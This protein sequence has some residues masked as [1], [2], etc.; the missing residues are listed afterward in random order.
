MSTLKISDPNLV[1]FSVIQLLDS[2]NQPF[3]VLDS[4]KT[5]KGDVY[6]RFWDGSAKVIHKD[7]KVRLVHTPGGVALIYLQEL[8]AKQLDEKM[9]EKIN[10]AKRKSKEREKKEKKG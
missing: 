10:S 8:R 5:A 4:K 3:V 1:P 9:D 7:A 6:I 2:P